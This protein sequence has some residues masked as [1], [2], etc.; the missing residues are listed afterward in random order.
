MAEGKIAI[1]GISDLI[2]IFKIFGIDAFGV[3]NDE[4]ALEV[5]NNLSNK[6][7]KLIIVL[8]SVSGKILEE[9]TKNKILILP[10]TYSHGNIGMEMIR[11][12][13]EKALGVDILEGEG[14][15]ERKN[16]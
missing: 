11:K 10:D 12:Q 4:Q 2:E 15:Y 6:D 7:Y 13:I 14:Y 16:Y 8:E 3:A 5:F 9:K 1:I